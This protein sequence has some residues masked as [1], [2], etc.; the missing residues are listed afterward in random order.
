MTTFKEIVDWCAERLEECATAI[1]A[2]GGERPHVYR[3][4]EAGMANPAAYVWMEPPATSERVDSC[5]IRHDLRMVL[6][7]SVLPRTGVGEDYLSVETILD[8]ALPPIY[9]AI[10]GMSFRQRRNLSAQ[11]FR[12]VRDDTNG[13]GAEKALVVEVP[14]VIPWFHDVPPAT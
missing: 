13:E 12:V 7:F 4:W 1:Q 8:A 11:P 2:A 5:T 10:P 9:A 14:L 6:C 3:W